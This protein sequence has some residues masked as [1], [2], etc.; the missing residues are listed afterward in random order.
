MNL[1][2]KWLIV[3][4]CAVVLNFLIMLNTVYVFAQWEDRFAI[5][6]PPSPC[7]TTLL[8]AVLEGDTE[9]AEFL[10]E[11]GADPNASLETCRLLNFEEIKK[12]KDFP[13][14]S[15][16]LYIA[17]KRFSLSSLSSLSSSGSGAMYNLLRDYGAN[18]STMNSVGDTP[19]SIW[20]EKRRWMNLRN[21]K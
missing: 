6:S 1:F 4:L 11:Y 16:L 5:Q 20:L 15:S 7:P 8:W 21:V 10:L 12:I 14:G 18:K 19:E 17:A 13:P 2:Y 9:V 3:L